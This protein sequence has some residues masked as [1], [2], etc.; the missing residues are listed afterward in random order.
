MSM[1]RKRKVNCTLICSECKSKDLQ[2]VGETTQRDPS[3]MEF[4]FDVKGT[5]A[6]NKYVEDTNYQ[7]M[8]IDD[9]NVECNKCH[10][11]IWLDQFV[12][13]MASAELID[14]R[15]VEWIIDHW[16]RQVENQIN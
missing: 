6:V 1:K 16:M 11:V 3:T 9:I 14:N 8:E 2:I 5:R 4:E 15:D 13:D 7:E 10:H 12:E